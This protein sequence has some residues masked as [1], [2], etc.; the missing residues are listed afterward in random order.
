MNKLSMEK[1]SIST[2]AGNSASSEDGGLPVVIIGA[3]P[4]GLTAALELTR[5][6]RRCIVLES[7]PEYVGGIA[8]TVNYKGFRLDIG[9]HRFYTMIDEITNWWHEVLPDDFIEVNRISR[10]YYDKKFLDY[11]LRAWNALSKMGLWFAIVA[12]SSHIYRKLRPIKPEISFRDWVVNHFGDRLFKTFFESYTEKVWG[13][14]CTE[15][16][17]DWAAQ[18]I[19]GLSLKR[20]IIRALKPNF[21]RKDDPAFKSLIDKFEYPRLGCGMIWERAQELVIEGGGEVVLDRKVVDIKTNGKMLKQIECVDSE[22][23]RYTY[24]CSAVISSM[25]LRDL[26]EAFD[27][28]PPDVLEAARNLRY[29][30]FLTVGLKVNRADSFPDNWIY[31]HDPEV[32][33]GRVQNFKNWSAE[34][35]P[36]PNVTFLGLEYFCFEGDGLW[37]MKDEDLIALGKK[38][39]DQ[40]G[41]ADA[42]EIDDGC[43]VRM[44]KAYPIYD[45]KYKEAV[46]VIRP[47]IQG[48]DNIWS[49]GR[50]GMHQYNNQDHSMMTALMSARSLM[51]TED[52]DA[53]E[54]NH[55]AEY[56]EERFV[57]KRVE[58]DA[59]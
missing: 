8:R 7:D 30:D 59:S 17:A 12:V 44:P 35:V 24:P 47:W 9:G 36:D 18:R 49:A 29:R 38:E 41:L 14:K 19:Q 28:V 51:G 6:G 22:G 55:N 26:V 32:K 2:E 54:I 34:M 58:S 42:R 40:I 27:T 56:L 46:E 16:S 50:N 33:L 11:P 5:A 39:I 23:K 43:V 10:I 4:A 3:G 31:V 25:A 57:P 1:E 13:I 15:I 45:G 21:G 37:N 48:L 20:V 53:W 52:R